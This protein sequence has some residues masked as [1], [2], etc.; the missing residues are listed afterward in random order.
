M[1]LLSAAVKKSDVLRMGGEEVKLT[2]RICM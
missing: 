1:K 2:V